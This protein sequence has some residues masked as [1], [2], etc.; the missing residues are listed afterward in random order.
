MRMSI[1]LLFEWGNRAALTESASSS[2]SILEMFAA[3][4]A[5]APERVGGD[6]RG[7]LDELSRT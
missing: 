7:S 4:V 3:Q 1:D 6:V 5:R 2:V